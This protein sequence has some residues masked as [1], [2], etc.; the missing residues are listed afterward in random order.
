MSKRK[1]SIPYPDFLTVAAAADRLGIG[2][3]AVQ[4]LCRAGDLDSVQL[5][6]DWRI[7]PLAVNLRLA[8]YGKGPI[9]QRERPNPRRKSK[10]G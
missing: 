1:Q 2:V 6:R 7:D 9:P 10:A 4:T 8:K 5:G 3:R